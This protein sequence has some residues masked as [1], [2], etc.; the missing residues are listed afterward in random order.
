MDT[1]ENVLLFGLHLLYKNINFFVCRLVD[2]GSISQ[3]AGSNSG[4]RRSQTSSRPRE[5]VQPIMSLA[6]ST[7]AVGVSV[8]NASGG[9]VNFSRCTLFHSN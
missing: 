2:L 3:V 4:L 7:N 6:A 9:Y 8:I 5:D 1:I